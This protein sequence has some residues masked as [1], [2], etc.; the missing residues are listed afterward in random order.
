[1]ISLEKEDLLGQGSFGRVVRA[2]DLENRE[3]ALVAKIMEI[4]TQTKLD[5]LQSELNVLESLCSEH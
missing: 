1:M 2:Y 4:G 5:C 3:E